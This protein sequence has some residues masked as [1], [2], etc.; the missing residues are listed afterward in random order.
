[1][2]VEIGEAVNQERGETAKGPQNEGVAAASL[3][4]DVPRIPSNLAQRPETSDGEKQP[5]RSHNAGAREPPVGET[6]QVVVAG[7]FGFGVDPVGSGIV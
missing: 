2:E 7:A 4:L 1:M 6:I 3:G 5:G